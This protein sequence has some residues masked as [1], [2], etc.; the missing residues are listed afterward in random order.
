MT[1]HKLTREEQIRG[2]EKA[3]ANSKTPAALKAGARKRL[4]QLKRK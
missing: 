1:Q 2:C 4:E 3:I